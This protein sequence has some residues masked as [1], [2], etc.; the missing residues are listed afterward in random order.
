M[1]R[2]V[3]LANAFPYGNWEPFLSTELE[4]LAGFDRIDVM[5]LSVRPEQ[6]ASK[7][8][9]PDNTSAYPIAYRSRAFYVL[10]CLRV[11]FDANLYR[12]L[13]HLARTRT[14]SPS[15]LVTLFVFLSRAH[16]EAAQCRR[17]L[18]RQAGADPGDSVVFYSYRLAYQPYMAWILRRRYPRSVS[19]ARAHRADLYEEFSPRGYL[20]LREHTMRHLDRIYCVAEHGRDYLNGR[21]AA[22]RAKTVVSRLGTADRGAARDWPPRGQGLRLVTCLT[23]VPVKRLHL[24]IDALAGATFDVQWDHFG[25]GPLREALA[26]RAQLVLDGRVSLAFR[27]FISNAD[28]VTEYVSSPRHLLVNVSAS[29]GVPVSIMEAL[30]TGTPVVATDVGGTS[31]LVRTG[32]NG[33]LLPADPSPEQILRAVESIAQTPEEEY[34]AMRRRARQ[35]WQERSDARQ[36]YAAFASELI[37][38]DPG[39]P[40]GQT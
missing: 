20:P 27:G 26:R 31:E 37:G 25:E 9:L 7:R 5:S 29:E 10:A 13:A 1:K 21:S 6:R 23:L 28:L 8:P 33:V 40:E 17:V 16:H 38:L 18:A 24:L 12:E 2:L 11:L 39:P 36:L 15:R 34:A 32:V 30:S 35:T 19:V 14:L 4:Y 22:A 3:I